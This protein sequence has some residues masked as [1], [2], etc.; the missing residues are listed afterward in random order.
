LPFHSLRNTLEEEAAAG[1][2]KI[3]HEFI[4]VVA[5]SLALFLL[6]FFFCG[7]YD[8]IASTKLIF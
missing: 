4:L 8:Q 2:T 3:C 6:V 5:L 1:A 7:I